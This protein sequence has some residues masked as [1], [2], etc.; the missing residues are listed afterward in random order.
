ME[1]I[2][3]SRNG[4]VSERQRGYIEE[5]L[6]KLDR[7]LDNDSKV[8]VEIGSETHR[9]SGEVYRAQVTL[10][11]ENGTIVRA[12]EQGSDLFRAIDDVQGKLQRQLT[13]Y[14]D[15]HWKRGKVRRDAEPLLEPAAVAD[16]DGAT[17]RLVRTKEFMLKP[18]FVD[19]A[20]EQMELLGHT[21]FVFRNAE[22]ERTSV[23]YRRADGNYGLISPTDG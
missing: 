1:L 11:A 14:K 20:V 2:V 12:E 4:K 8:T 7:F 3:K 21:F 5:K 19:D 18:M 9:A 6:S 22:T 16:D 13:R 17:P 10:V 15:R 23:V